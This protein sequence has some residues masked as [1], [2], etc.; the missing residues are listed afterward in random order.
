MSHLKKPPPTKQSV[1]DITDHLLELILKIQEGSEDALAD[2]YEATVAP[3][4]ALAH[5]ILRDSTEAEDV[6][7]R[8]F[9]DA[10]SMASRYN[11]QRG[12]VFT[13]LTVMC[14]SRALDSL[15][16]HNR[17]F[18]H[19]VDDSTPMVDETGSTPDELLNLLQNQSRVRT[20][21]ER[22]HANQRHLVAMSFLEG[23]SHSEIASRTGMALGT[24][25]SHIR[26]A[27]QQ[28][29]EELV[30]NERE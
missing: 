30:R 18:E 22:L 14:R 28:L 13:W 25:K 20:A 17:R 29:K 19:L 5:A 12:S 7:S 6:V 24:V 11:P 21:L 10:W 4:Y 9:T 27:L 26:G 2:L 8:T 16:S 23:L 3:L 15:R 1:D